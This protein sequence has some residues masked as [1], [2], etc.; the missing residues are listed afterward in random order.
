MEEQYYEGFT[1]DEESSSADEDESWWNFQ[2]WTLGAGLMCGF[3]SS[4]LV[5]LF[6]K[7]PSV[8][9]GA[10]N[11][12]KSKSL[13]DTLS[14][15]STNNKMALVIR[16]DLGMSKGKAAAQCAHAAVG[17]YKKASKTTPELLSQW[18]TFGSAKVTMKIDSEAALYDL[19]TKAEAL[20][21]CAYEVHDAGRTQVTR[22]SVTVLAVGPGPVKI[23][24]QVT[25]HLKLY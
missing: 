13:S 15:F 8:T 21:L 7:T 23:V 18:E 2:L 19:K 12:S 17:C 24:D 3:L 1:P 9:S 4:A 22:G 25:G 14:T 20:G 10:I 5:R 11:T 6:Q 16:C